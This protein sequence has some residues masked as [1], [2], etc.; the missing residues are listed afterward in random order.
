MNFSFFFSPTKVQA[1]GK[2]M[3]GRSSSRNSPYFPAGGIDLNA[4]ALEHSVHSECYPN[5]KADSNPMEI[6][7]SV[8]SSFWR[9]YLYDVGR[10]RD[11]EL[12]SVARHLACQDQ[13][14]SEPVSLLHRNQ[15]NW[16]KRKRAG[17]M[18]NPKNPTVV[19]WSTFWVILLYCQ[20][21]IQF[22]SWHK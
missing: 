7:D 10:L 11:R 14:W 17:K 5:F 9:F 12:I 22:L 19:I 3:S 15:E 2:F 21:I 4:W 20:I 8:P 18:C 13:V 16:W 1:I 6:Q